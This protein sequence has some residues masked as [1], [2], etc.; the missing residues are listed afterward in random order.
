MWRH[1][2]PRTSRSFSVAPRCALT[3]LSADAEPTTQPANASSPPLTPTAAQGRC[4]EDDS[5]DG[6]ADRDRSQHRSAKP[7]ASQAPAAVTSNARWPGL[8]ASTTTRGAR[9]SKSAARGA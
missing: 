6:D 7:R 3:P 9:S 5:P 2:A 8:G 4:L 1:A